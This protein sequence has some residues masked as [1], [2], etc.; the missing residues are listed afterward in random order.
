MN[1]INGLVA[2][3][4]GVGAAWAAFWGLLSPIGDQ[5]TIACVQAAPE[6]CVWLDEG[7]MHIMGYHLLMN[8]V[9]FGSVNVWYCWQLYKMDKSVT[10][11]YPNQGA[12]VLDHHTETDQPLQ[13]DQP[14]VPEHHSG[15]KKDNRSF[16]IR[17]MNWLGWE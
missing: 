6:L 13:A 4:Q 3:W 2:A 10:W 8:G 12:A 9:I 17:L 1:A 16:L 7:W 15:S 11:Y 14:T 5:I